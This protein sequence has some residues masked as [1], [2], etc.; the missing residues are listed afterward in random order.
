[1]FFPGIEYSKFMNDD[2]YG[3]GPLESHREVFGNLNGTVH[4]IRKE[5]W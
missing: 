5:N 2:Q 4:E 3:D 1:M